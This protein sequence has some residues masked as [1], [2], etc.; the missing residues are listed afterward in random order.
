MSDNKL[1][2]TAKEKR[3]LDYIEKCKTEGFQPT[4]GDVCRECHT[5]PWTL[6]SKTY[7]GLR[8]KLG[9]GAEP[10]EL[11][12]LYPS[13]EMHKKRHSPKGVP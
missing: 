13:K 11:Q 3:Y 6:F 8:M 1:S 2:L 12:R 7:P 9:I 5:T 10:H 4:I